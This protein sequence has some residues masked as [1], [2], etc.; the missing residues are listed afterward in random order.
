MPEPLDGTVGG[1]EQVQY[2][3]ALGTSERC[4]LRSWSGTCLDDLGR[5]RAVP[6]VTGDSRHAVRAG[7]G[8]N[9]QQAVPGPP[10]ERAAGTADVHE[11][12]PANAV[13]GEFRLGQRLGT[14]RLDWVPPEPGHVHVRLPRRL[15]THPV[16]TNRSDRAR[17]AT[18]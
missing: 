1:D 18:A 7:T 5:L 6:A 3:E 4:E 15:N 8:G 17:S 9:G 13:T 12:V 16:V 14:K 10:G 2:V 11:P